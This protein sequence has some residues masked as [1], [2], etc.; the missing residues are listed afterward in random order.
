MLF[1]LPSQGVVPDGEIRQIEQDG[2]AE[3]LR[4]LGVTLVADTCWCMITEPVF[5]PSA[6]VVLTNSGKYAHYADGLTGRG[7]RFGSLA[8]CSDQICLF[9]IVGEEKFLKFSIS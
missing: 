2:T 3:G 9:R 5:P 8:D 4:H 7:V 6:R 1:S